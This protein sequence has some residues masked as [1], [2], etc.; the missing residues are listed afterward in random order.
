M[1]LILMVIVEAT[2][3]DRFE[4]YPGR[5]ATAQDSGSG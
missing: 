2:V 5:I 4:Y 1:G 3:S